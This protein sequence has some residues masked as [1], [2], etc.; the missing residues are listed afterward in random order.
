MAAH[1]VAAAESWSC[2]DASHGLS[3][4]VLV[5]ITLRLQQPLQRIF[6]AFYKAFWSR[7]S[8]VHHWN[9]LSSPGLCLPAPGLIGDAQ[10]QAVHVEFHIVN[11]PKQLL[12]QLVRHRWLARAHVHAVVAA[13]AIILNAVP[14]QMLQ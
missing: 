7:L 5:Q 4:K 1:T 6:H 11:K 2:C 9:A 14:D 12:Q 3:R 8:T 13:A 10:W